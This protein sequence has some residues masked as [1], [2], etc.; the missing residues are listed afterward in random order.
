MSIVPVQSQLG[1]PAGP[2]HLFFDPTALLSLADPW[3]RADRASRLMQLLQNILSMVSDVRRQAVVEL[4]ENQRIPKAQVARHIGVTPPR[5]DQ[6]V[7]SARRSATPDEAV[8]A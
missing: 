8:A 4:V 1:K 7:I 3:E 5:V 2:T 6:L